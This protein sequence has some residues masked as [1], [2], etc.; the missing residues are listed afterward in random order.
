MWINGPCTQLTA[1][2]QYYMHSNCA[3]LAGMAPG[4][5]WKK[6]RAKDQRVQ[7]HILCVDPKGTPG[8]I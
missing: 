3:V 1:F 2:V 8:V 5:E 6:Q 7:A 4:S